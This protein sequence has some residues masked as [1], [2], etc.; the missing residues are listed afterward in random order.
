MKRAI[1]LVLALATLLMFGCEQMP[2][3]G[4]ET[5]DTQ[6]DT[7]FTLNPYVEGEGAVQD[8]IYANAE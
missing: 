5:L 8:I 1:I 4:S 7:P 6:N 3:K 2:D